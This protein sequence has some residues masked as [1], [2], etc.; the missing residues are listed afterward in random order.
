MQR[1]LILLGKSGGG[2]GSRT[3]VRRYVPAELYMCVRAWCFTAGARSATKNHRRLSVD[4]SR[5]DPSTRQIA[6]SLLNDV[7]S[8]PAGE[9]GRDVVACLGGESELRIRSYGVFHRIYESMVLD[10]HPVFA[11]P[12]RSRVAPLEIRR[13]VRRRV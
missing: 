3:R 1:R 5:Y 11:Y 10:M 7:R 6:A 2:G 13:M 4:K 12:R 9:G 8:Y